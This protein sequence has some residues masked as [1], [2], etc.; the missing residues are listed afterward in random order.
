MTRSRGDAEKHAENTFVGTAP[1]VPRPLSPLPPRS[2]RFWPPTPVEA[3]PPIPKIFSPRLR[4][5]SISSLSNTPRDR[6]GFLPQVTWAGTWANRQLSFF[7]GLL[8]RWAGQFP[9][10]FID[11][12]HGL[13]EPRDP[14]A[15]PLSG[16]PIGSAGQ[17][18]QRMGPSGCGRAATT[19]R[20]GVWD[21]NWWSCAVGTECNVRLVEAQRHVSAP[22]GS[23][24]SFRAVPV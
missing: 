12:W 15:V 9:V 22:P 6:P 21:G 20:S 14:G 10:T 24:L 23:R 16:R 1:G 8:N 7:G 2:F 5:K 3:A 17:M 19:E 18:A 13:L 4:V 11:Q